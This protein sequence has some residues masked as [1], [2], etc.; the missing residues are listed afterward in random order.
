MSYGNA[1]WRCGT[2]ALTIT[3][4]GIG[5]KLDAEQK[6]NVMTFRSNTRGRSKYS[7][8]SNKAFLKWR[9]TIA[10]KNEVL[11]F[12]RSL[13]FFN[14]LRSTTA[15]TSCLTKI[16][17][18]RYSPNLSRLAKSRTRFPAAELVAGLLIKLP[19]VFHLGFHAL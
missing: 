12:F 3:N 7:R 17:V 10:L 14:L 8:N 4:A 16:W 13:I 18:I 15:S 19:L 6:M 1:V 5:L 2:V 9:E 11:V